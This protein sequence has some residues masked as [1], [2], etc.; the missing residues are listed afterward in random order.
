MTSLERELMAMAA[1]EAAA[2][3]PTLN[4]RAFRQFFPARA[5][6]TERPKQM[7]GVKMNPNGTITIQGQTLTR[8]QF[9]AALEENMKAQR[10]DPK[11]AFNDRKHPAHEAAVSEMQ[12]GYKFLGGELTEGDEKQ[13]LTQW[14]DATTEENEVTDTLSPYR[15]IAEIVKS[16]E[17][18]VALQR[19]K[20]GLPLDPAQKANRSAPQSVRDG[21]RHDCAA[22]A[23]E[24]GRDVQDHAAADHPV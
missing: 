8:D 19:A 18:K 7:N 13:I 12:L 16:P 22:R 9:R 3:R 14:A 4:I 17:G 20:V 24:Q 2:R 5:A 23:S 21:D 11:S 1:R 15:E 6:A 10:A